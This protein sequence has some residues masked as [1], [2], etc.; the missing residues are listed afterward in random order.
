MSMCVSHSGQWRFPSFTVPPVSG[1]SQYDGSALI[2]NAA[3]ISPVSKNWPPH[4]LHRSRTASPAVT[5][6][7]RILS[8]GQDLSV[9]E[10]SC[11]PTAVLPMV[12]L[13]M[14][15]AQGFRITRIAPQGQRAR[16]GRELGFHALVFLA[17]HVASL[18]Q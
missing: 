8:S 15:F 5:C 9:F 11:L 6:C 7:M 17:A 4:L 2:P 16:G 3:N 10:R 12:I 13:P 18:S 1:R 14:N